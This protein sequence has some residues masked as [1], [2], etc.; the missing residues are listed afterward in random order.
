[1]RNILQKLEARDMEG[2]WLAV[3][4]KEVI[5]SICPAMV[6]M[7]LYLGLRSLNGVAVYSH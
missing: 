5:A 6:D 3:L 1:M 2:P 7:F 4:L